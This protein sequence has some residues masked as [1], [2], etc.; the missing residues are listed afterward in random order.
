MTTPVAA[1]LVTPAPSAGT[2][3]ARPATC[4]SRDVQSG[5]FFYIAE[6]LT[7]Y[8][9][10][11][12]TLQEVQDLQELLSVHRVVH[13]GT[14]SPPRYTQVH[15]GW[16]LWHRVRDELGPATDHAMGLVRVGVGTLI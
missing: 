11:Q 4:V 2:G 12:R 16:V 1:H 9:Q 8:F 7:F 10:V 3:G 13:P 5:S 15:P 6:H 14:P